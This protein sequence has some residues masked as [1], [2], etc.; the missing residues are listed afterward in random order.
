MELAAMSIYSE[1]PNGYMEC[2]P[3]ARLQRLGKFSDVRIETK[4][5]HEVAAHRVVLASR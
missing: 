5:G 2:A 1:E 3:F 4:D